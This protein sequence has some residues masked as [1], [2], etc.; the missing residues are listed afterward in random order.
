M[1]KKENRSCFGCMESSIISFVIN[2]STIVSY[3]F[4]YLTLSHKY[5]KYLRVFQRTV[6]GGGQSKQA[7]SGKLI[8][9]IKCISWQCSEASYS[10]AQRMYWHLTKLYF[11]VDWQ[12]ELE[13]LAQTNVYHSLMPRRLKKYVTLSVWCCMNCKLNSALTAGFNTP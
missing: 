6:C 12:S 7:T 11:T 5:A 13:N 8:N 4:I 9:I 3:F 10:L 2:E 1:I